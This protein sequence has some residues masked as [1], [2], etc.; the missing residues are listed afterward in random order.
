MLLGV[1]ATCLFFLGLGR[2]PLLEP[3]EG[4]NAEVAR[5]MLFSGD[6]I[7]PHFNELPYLDKPVVF[8]WLVAGSFRLW[9]I[10]EWAARFPS[11][12]MALVTL[13]LTWFLAQRMF[14]DTAGLRAGLILAT[15]PL[16]IV[17][18]RL[19]V[20][21][22]TLTCLVT[23][24]MLCFWCAEV[25]D[26]RP[27]NLDAVAFAAMGVATITKGP[28]GF[29][30][31]LLSLVAYHALRR[32][33][34]E[35]K[36]I[37]WVLGLGVFLIATLPWFLTVCIR[38]PDFPKYAFWQESLQRFASGQARRRGGILYY[39]PVY[40]AGFFPWSFLLAFAA[41][42]RRRK[43]KE[44]VDETHRPVAFLLA[45]AG[46]I[47]VF[48]SIS[49]S[50]L[51]AYF[52][53]A[54]IPLS[55]L[56]G[57]AWREVEPAAGGRPP[58]WLKAGLTS[59][60]A[61]GFVIVAASQLV[62]LNFVQSR[63]ERKMP[64]SVILLIK[65]SLL[66]TGLIVAFLALAAG[67]YLGTRARGPA[68]SA[69]TFALL[70]L[71]VPVLLVRW[72]VP[73]RIYVESVSSRQLARAILESPERDFPIYGYYCFRTSLPFY[74]GLPVRLVTSEASEL[75]SN[76]VAS[77]L[78]ELRSQRP[79]ANASVMAPN[80][81]SRGRAWPAPFDKVFL[82]AI[83][84]RALARSRGAPLLVLVRNSQVADLAQTVGD[85]EPLWSD[86]QYSVWKVPGARLDAPK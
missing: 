70:A 73:L 46:V 8:F 41:W 22:M 74:L 35:L 26:P 31:P 72:M 85:I 45:W 21:D 20:F 59:L 14:G 60:V 81:A 51:P 1:V 28:V 62:Q 44:L 34:R 29:L 54:V 37:H 27:A 33:F 57:E 18:S 47:F 42:S 43:W 69:V 63:L 56:L 82:D 39:V 64:S 10:S 80:A 5:E 55:I 84:L 4:R 53:P 9:G 78:R 13:L 86:W 68:P 66:Y 16:V 6:W 77:R 32:G 52:L 38:H 49:Q 50:K 67:R 12:V 24:T 48:F 17:F 36:R 23:L 65:P 2:L 11:A 75:T 79:G 61:A 71:T 76:Y 30:L 25:E 15:S 7:T 58:G 83:E 3:D 19:V 40:L